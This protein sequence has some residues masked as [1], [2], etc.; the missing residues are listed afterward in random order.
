LNE[1]PPRR[2]GGLARLLALLAVGAGFFAVFEVGF[3][4]A[5]RGRLPVL[6]LSLALALLAAWNPARGLVVFSAVFPLAGLGDRAFGGADAVA[7]PILLFA[8]FAAG[9][10]FR[11]LYDFENV[12][13]PTRADGP[14]RALAALWVAAALL[15]AGRARTLWAITHGLGLR[16]VNV[17]GLLDPGAIRDAVLSLAAVGA[18]AAFFFVLRRA[19]DAAR[20]AALT[21]ATWGVA[22]SAAVAVAAR[23]G[24]GPGETS[25]FWRMTGR[26][27]GASV[28]P[29]ALGLLCA[30]AL[31]AALSALASGGRKA[32]ALLALPAAA[33]LYLSGSRS[34]IGAA[35]VGG[36]LL[37][38]LPGVTA[39]RRVLILAAIL[40]AGAA[41][42]LLAPRRDGSA[43]ER[44][45]RL[46]DP[47]I[48]AEDRSS[49]RTLL[50]DAALR[51]FRRE[52]VAGG[53]LGAFAWELPNLLTET[54]RSLPLRDN[55]GNAY[56]Q[57]LAET[58]LVGF[59]VTLGVCLALAREAWLAACGT[60]SA[61]RGA[62][63]GVLAFLGALATGSHWFAPDVALYFF[64]LAA[65]CART[66]TSPASARAVRLRVLL[67]AVYVVAAGAAF[68]RTRSPEEA[69]RYRPGLG[70]HA[71]ET[72]RGGPFWWTQ[73]RFAIRLEAG[74]SMALGLAHFTPE[75]RPVTLT[76]ESGG[77]TVF[78]R[79]LAPGDGVRLRLSAGA[80]P[81]VVRFTLSRAFVPKRLG[82][83]GDPRQLGLVAVFP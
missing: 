37:L 20:R 3:P 59:L 40:A 9:W 50:W 74:R 81:R 1:P 42:L 25:A 11:F 14:L 45:R 27:S 63:A 15:S 49:S 53:G 70:F 36:A 82:L 51:M 38:V 26:S 34:G 57:S 80:A 24:I 52:P 48:S 68:V 30:L 75:G 54:G 76:A 78:E 64:L 7:W 28:D 35:A 2:P 19:G 58:G 6:V 67:V 32:L 23:A 5:A 56:L 41:A 43:V 21:A 10:T 55:P 8:G 44:L 33:G 77:R 22:V 13:D 83:S 39:R 69:F 47:A 79:Q 29:N 31:V 17:D 72:G 71:K 4:P 66:R 18:G 65:V 60:D 46:A 61:C 12:P 73:R 62:G 16:A